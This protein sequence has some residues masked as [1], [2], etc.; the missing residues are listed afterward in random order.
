MSARSRFLGSRLGVLDRDAPLEMTL[1]L[2][3]CA[4]NNPEARKKLVDGWVSMED[5][6]QGNDL[7]AGEIDRLMDLEVRCNLKKLAIENDN[8]NNEEEDA[9]EEDKPREPVTFDEV[10]NLASNQASIK[11]FFNK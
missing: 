2:K 6:E 3:E 9:L 10:N 4:I 11:A 7:L 1:T 5:N 8:E